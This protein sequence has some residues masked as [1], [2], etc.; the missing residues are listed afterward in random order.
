MKIVC[1][2]CQAKYSIADEKVRGKV[3]KIRCKK[4]SHVIVVRGSGEVVT[5]ARRQRVLVL[6][7][8]VARHLAR[9]RLAHRRRRRA[10]RAPV[11]GRRPRPPLARRDH[12][13]HVHLAGGPLGLGE[14]L[15]L[16]RVRRGRRGGQPVRRRRAS[17]AASRPTDP[18]LSR[19][20]ARRRSSCPGGRRAPACPPSPSCSPRL[21]PERTA[22]PPPSRR[23]GCRRSRRRPR[24]R[25]SG[26]RRR[27]RRA[28]WAAASRR[29]G[30]TGQRHENSVL[31]SLANLEA[32]AK[33]AQSSMP[34]A[35]SSA[36][37]VSNST[38]TEGSGLIDIRAMANMTLGGVSAKSDTRGDDLPAFSA[39]QFSPVAP[40]LLPMG[41]SRHPPLGDRRARRAGPGH[42]GARGGGREDVQLAPGRRPPT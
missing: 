3:F 12:A 27:Q 18:P 16:A 11:G 10:G 34:M 41:S 6:R 7:R 23:P 32:L 29:R 31:F 28:R 25:T 19:R 21:A 14:G 35:R 4:C 37:P 17:R 22:P 20:R 42:R 9:R 40:V 2:A 15:H 36:Q 13:R 24:S 33:P 26:R 38:T 5:A 30:L 8:L 39:P 1:E